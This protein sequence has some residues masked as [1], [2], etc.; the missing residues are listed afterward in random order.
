M[1][2]LFF[3]RKQG[4]AKVLVETFEDLWHLENI[5]ES[6]DKVSSSSIRTVKFGDKEE[7]KHVFIT[8]LLEEVE[9]SK[10]VNRLRLRGKI[11]YGTPEDFV[12]L[13]RYHTLDI[14]Q[15]DKLQIEKEW[16]S[17]HIKRLK[18]SEK[19]SKRELVS[20][21]VM[22]EEKAITALLRSYGVEYGPEIRNYGSKRSED[23]EKQTQQYYGDILKHIENS[24]N[25]ILIAGPGFAK[26]NF[27]K[28]VKTRNPELSSKLLTDSCSYAERSGVNELMKRGVF[29]RISGE[30]RLEAE[31]QVIEEFITELNK[32]GLVIYG[33]EEVK[34]S[35]VSGAVSHLLVLD[36]LLRKDKNIQSLVEQCNSFGSKISILSKEGDPGIKLQGFGGVVAFLRFKI[37]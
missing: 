19:E 5:L 31:S 37:H 24:K 23:Y 12:Q 30:Q 36:E 2:I 18:D 29:E 10:S 6:G 11:V 32:G 27:L 7:K 26:E 33:F 25:K 28:F 1:K 3:D 21:V 34:K 20:I 4:I 13:G 14:Q 8:L 15:N 9:F 16:K 22:D 35:V 17:F